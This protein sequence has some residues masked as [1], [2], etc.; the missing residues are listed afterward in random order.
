MRY[1]ARLS[2]IM[3][4]LIMMLALGATAASAQA[5][6]Y[7]V[8]RGDVLSRIAQQHGVTVNC[9]AQVNRINN[10]NLIYVGQVLNIAAC[11][12]Q[13][14]GQAQVPM[15]NPVN[16]AAPSNLT[17]SSYVVQPGDTLGRIAQRYG[18]NVSCLVRVNQLPNQNVIKRGQVL[19]IDPCIQQGGGIAPLPVSQTY[20][21]QRGDKMIDIAARFGVDLM[22]LARANQIASPGYIFTGE[23]LRI[24]YSCALS[25]QAANG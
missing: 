24:D 19:Q 15:V 12:S 13:G 4:L 14:G 3:T 21:V 11:Q 22:C 7:I 16:P 2:L 18:V 17:P 1:S 10:P 6:G 8:S 23:T 20:V 9:L 5:G 25:A